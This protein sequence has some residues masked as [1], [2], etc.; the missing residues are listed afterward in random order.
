MRRNLR[1][2][3]IMDLICL[4]CSLACLLRTFVCVFF[5]HLLSLSSGFLFS[6]RY[7]FFAYS[8]F[9]TLSAK[10][11]RPALIAKKIEEK[12]HILK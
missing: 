8:H 1:A 4:L 11:V 12:R 2:V 10:L 9:V 7:M 5:S 3:C 6:L